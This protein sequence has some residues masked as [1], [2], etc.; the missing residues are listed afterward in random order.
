MNVPTM[1]SDAIGTIARPEPPPADVH[2]AV[3]EDHDQRDDADP[4]DRL[5]VRQGNR[6]SRARP[7]RKSAGAGT[8]IA[9]ARAW[10]RAS[11]SITPPRRRARS[12]RNRSARPRRDANGFLTTPS[13]A[14]IW[15]ASDTWPTDAEDCCVPLLLALAPAGSRRHVAAAR[16]PQNGTLSVRE[17]SR[18]RPARR[19]RQHDR[20]RERPDH[21]HRPEAVRLASA[22]SSTAR[23]RRSTGTSKTTV[24]Q[25]KNLRFRL[26]GARFQ[27]RIQGKAIF[28]SAI[29]RGDGSRSTASAIA[30]GERLLR[31]RLVAE[32]RA[33]TSSLPGRSG[34]RV[35][36]GRLRARDSGP[37]WHP[38]RAVPSDHT[39]NSAG[40]RGRGLDRLVRLALPE[41]RGLRRAR[42]R[43][44]RA[45]R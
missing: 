20:P 44:R 27:I 3:E 35:R 19:A 34:N 39:A 21:D 45:R 16:A 6:E 40:R 5:D 24:Y 38:E 43:D 15:T 28:L 41:E 2:A 30:S 14:G 18:R 10:P 17:A 11:A 26:I 33:A 29:A 9:L 37:L 25:G 7:S 22:R 12:A 4:L 23:R 32:R 13:F 1:P 8:G 31:R 36:P 42:R